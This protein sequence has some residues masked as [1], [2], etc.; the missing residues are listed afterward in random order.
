MRRTQG[1]LY[2]GML[3]FRLFGIP[4]G[5]T[6]YFWIGSAFL[7][8]QTGGGQDWVL[9]LSVWVGCVL[10]SIVAHELG[11]ALLARKYG[12]QPFVVLYQLGGLTYMPG[13][14]FTRGQSIL[15]SLAGPAAG[16]TAFLAVRTVRYLL[17]STGNDDILYAP[18]QA[19]LAAHEAIGDLLWING[20]WTVF[21]LLPIQPLDGGQVLREVLGPNLSQVT[22]FIGAVCAVACCVGAALLG[23]YITAFFLGYL[24]YS[25]LTGNTRS[26]PGGVGT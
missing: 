17:L 7:S 10:V 6:L 2:Y 11:H 24:A 19:G 22:R 14:R 16:F 25:N 8:G 9:K 20:A 18:T 26:L 4:F 1:V 21:N 23:M 3:R 5:V 13:A 15:V 12:V